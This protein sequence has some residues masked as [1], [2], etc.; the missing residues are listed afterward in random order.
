MQASA[1]GKDAYFARQQAMN[2]QKPEG[3]APNKVAPAKYCPPRHRHAFK[4]SFL[5]FTVSIVYESISH[6]Q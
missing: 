1:A 5:D 6:L 2:A 3:V 4:P